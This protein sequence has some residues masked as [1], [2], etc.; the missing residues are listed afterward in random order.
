MTYT[1]I[2][3]ESTGEVIR[4]IKES[5]SNNFIVLDNFHDLKQDVQKEFATALREFL[6]HHIRVIFVSVW[7]ES[8]KINARVPDLGNRVE[9]VRYR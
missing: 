5:I 9:T 7:K 6:F 2:N 8:T 3:W 4:A 1:N